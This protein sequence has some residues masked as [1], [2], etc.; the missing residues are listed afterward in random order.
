MPKRVSVKGK[1]ADL[2]FGDYD[3]VG[4]AAQPTDVSPGKRAESRAA[5]GGVSRTATAPASVAPVDA[6]TRTPVKGSRTKSASPR[7]SRPVS[8]ASRRAC[9]R[10]S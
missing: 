2:F 3:P 6:V 7:A 9:K 5:T 8:D 10:A 4:G 1:G